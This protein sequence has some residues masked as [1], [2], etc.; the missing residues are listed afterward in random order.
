MNSLDIIAVGFL[1]YFMFLGYLRGFIRQSISLATFLIS[2][3]MSITFY[4][5]LG[6]FFAFQYEMPQEIANVVSFFFI[7]FAFQFLFFIPVVIFYPKIPKELTEKN[8]NRWGGL[9]PAFVK[10]VVLL[11]FFLGTV[12]IFPVSGN[13]YI[14]DLMNGSFVGRESLKTSKFIENY[15][16]DIFGEAIS[17]AA[18]F[19]VVKQENDE[20]YELDFKV[21]SPGT[22]A[23][24]EN[25]MLELIN[26]ERVANDLTP[27][28]MDESL[29]KVAREQSLDM[30]V[31]GYFSH[32]NPEG[33]SP[34]DRMDEAGIEY[35]IAGENLALAPNVTIAHNGLMNSPG[36][37]ANILT[38]DFCKVGIG[39]MDGGVYG[40]MFSQEFSN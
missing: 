16:D 29:R 5:R 2:F 37:R 24:S 20:Y 4:S 15:V 6:S 40:K 18:N 19:L 36:H 21:S 34:F 3:F 35:M 25:T 22:D 28:V 31:R 1:L 27:L 12:N 23:V 14:N 38:A 8:W 30:L 10:G 39:V 17:E 13:D 9:F 26:R 7:W 33:E 32:T 11:L